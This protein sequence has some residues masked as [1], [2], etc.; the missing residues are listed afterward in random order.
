[1]NVEQS[2]GKNPEFPQADWERTP[3]SVKQWVESREERLGH[4]EQE[5]AELKKQLFRAAS[6]QR[7][8]TRVTE[9]DISQLI[10]T[11]LKESA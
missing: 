4:L 1:M 2:R 8:I 6:P 5:L 3:L 11:T 7:T 10:N 9:S